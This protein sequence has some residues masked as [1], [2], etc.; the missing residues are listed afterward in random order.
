MLKINLAWYLSVAGSEPG[1][2]AKIA[3]LTN[4]KR[5]VA[6]GA[7]GFLAF[8]GP[9]LKILLLRQPAQIQITASGR[10]RDALGREVRRQPANGTKASVSIAGT[11]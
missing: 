8:P 2:F 1:L 7:A 10:L 11:G 4:P 9:A 6:A 3:R 5:P